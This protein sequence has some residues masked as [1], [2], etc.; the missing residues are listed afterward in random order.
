MKEAKMKEAK[1]T[2]TTPGDPDEHIELKTHIGVGACEE[3]VS[4]LAEQAAEN[5]F[6]NE[7]GWEA[8]W[9]IEFSIFSNGQLIGKHEVSIESVPTFYAGESLMGAEQCTK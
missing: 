7:D 4:V 3:F 5:L 1:I 6:Y 9:P 8:G 2:Y